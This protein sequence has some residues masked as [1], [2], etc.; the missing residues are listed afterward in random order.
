MFGGIL[1]LRVSLL[2]V[3]AGGARGVVTCRRRLRV[4]PC[5]GGQSVGPVGKGSKLSDGGQDRTRVDEPL[6]GV[7]LKETAE[8]LLKCV[9]FGGE[10][11]ERLGGFG[12]SQGFLLL[13]RRSL[14]GPFLVL[15][16]LP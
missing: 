4:C 13:E 5:K 8:M 16:S 12:V 7:W 9:G 3:R 11:V 2:I 6:G 1:T 15:L 14:L 10:S